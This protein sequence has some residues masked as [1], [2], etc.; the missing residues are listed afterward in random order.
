MS[1]TETFETTGHVKWFS[2]SKGY[3]FIR[4]IEQLP[5]IFVGLSIV[6]AGRYGMLRS[7]ATITVLVT[8][9]KK[10]KLKALKILSLDNSTATQNER[11]PEEEHFRVIDPG[12]WEIA[13]VEKFDKIRGFGFLTCGN[14]GEDIFIHLETL[15]RC[16]YFDLNPGQCVMIRVGKGANGFAAADI[17]P[18]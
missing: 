12:D 18:L 5:D 4:P 2:P 13:T 15:L 8:E 7:G 6:R 1:E 14:Y 11:S 10:G 3:G 9:G 17:K 16:G